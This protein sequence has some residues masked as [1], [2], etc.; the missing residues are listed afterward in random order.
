MDIHMLNT[1]VQLFRTGTTV[2]TKQI[3]T[4][5]MVEISLFTTLGQIPTCE[6]IAFRAITQKMGSAESYVSQLQ[7]V[8]GITSS[9]IPVAFVFDTREYTKLGLG[10]NIILKVDFQSILISV[11]TPELEVAIALMNYWVSSI[12]EHL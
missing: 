10:R 9:L 3:Y 5:P 11:A 1:L 12:A 6:S 7:V 4:P 2:E 8:R